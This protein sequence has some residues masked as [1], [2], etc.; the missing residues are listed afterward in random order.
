MT[1]YPIFA[2]EAGFLAQASKCD[3]SSASA[4]GL[5]CGK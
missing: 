4:V 3:F 5:S 1:T 2:L